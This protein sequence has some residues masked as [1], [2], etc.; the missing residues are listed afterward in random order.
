MSEDLGGRKETD[1][2]VSP[3][4]EKFVVK[5]P[6]AFADAADH[7]SSVSHTTAKAQIMMGVTTVQNFA[8]RET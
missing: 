5:G 2:G 7:V 3:E 1:K 4:L 6:C 8:I